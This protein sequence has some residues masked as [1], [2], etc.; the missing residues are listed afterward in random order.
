MRWYAFWSAF[1][2]W[3]WAGA[4]ALVAQSTQELL[5][6]LRRLQEEVEQ[7][8][9]QVQ[10]EV[11][12]RRA[13]LEEELRL[14]R[15][16]L[17]EER[18]ADQRLPLPYGLAPAPTMSR[19]E[20]E[21]EL[22]ILREEI[23]ELRRQAAAQTE[24]SQAGGKYRVVAQVRTRFEWNDLDFVSGRANLQHLLRTR[25]GLEGKPREQTGLFVQV[26]DARLWGEEAST[27]SDG[28]ADHLDF[29]QAYLRLDNIFS[30]P[31]SV[32]LG[33]QELAYGN[34][35]LVGAV[36][37]HNI[38]RAFDAVKLRYGENSWVDLF[39]AKL[40]EKGEKDRNFYGLYGRVQIQAHTWEPYALFEHDKNF[41]A[42]RLRRL[43]LGAHGLGTFTGAT[44]HSLGYELEGAVQAGER[45]EQDVLAWMGTGALTYTSNHWRQHQLSLGADLLSGDDDPADGESKV[46]DTLFATNH[47]F[48]GLM[49]FF[50][51]IPAQTGQQGLLDLMLKASMRA[52]PPVKVDLHLHSFS[53]AK[54][55]EKALGQE[56]DAVVTYAHSPA[57]SLQWGALLF[58][59]GKAMEAM[60][61]GDEPAFKFYWQT[62][63]DF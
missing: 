59:P 47:K 55:N 18:G 35:R 49:D 63:M 10:A 62:Q 40:A 28:Q 3:C 60:Q 13:E 61:G 20:M 22:R 30:R 23:Q 57:T 25:L 29:H 11:E 43:T 56:V 4:D 50:L 37:W 21:A 53:L 36:G 52:G 12:Q 58:L 1:C 46:F 24:V 38:G 9:A 54:G 7:R 42:G 2:L 41:G 45:E 8:R 27:L 31:L 16:V 44:G 6:E 51:D 17:E 15:R 48:Y 14:L 32:V 26:Q 39:N 33:R 19:Q 5:E 34:E